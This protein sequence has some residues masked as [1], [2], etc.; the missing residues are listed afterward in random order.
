MNECHPREH[1]FQAHTKDGGIFCTKCGAMLGGGLPTGVIVMWNGT[2]DKVP[3]GWELCDGSRGTPDLREKFI[4]GAGSSYD[5]GGTGGR[6]QC[7][8]TEK[9][10]PAHTHNRNSD[11]I[12]ELP[13]METTLKTRDDKAN[14][15]PR[16]E[17][18]SGRHI[19]N[20]EQNPET[21]Y[22]MPYFSTRTGEAGAKKA[23]SNRFYV[24]TYY[25]LA[26][27]VKK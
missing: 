6:N 26:F 3:V 18:K 13:I 23:N 11:G 10:I 20:I 5:V 4:V 9:H 25:A 15:V 8:L 1:N 7:I 22:N 16:T 14:L 17:E 24:P 19:Y 2:I 12:R 27:I 21:V